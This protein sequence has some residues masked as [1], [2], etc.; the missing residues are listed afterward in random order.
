M[1]HLSRRRLVAIGPA[2][3]VALA[4][5]AHAVLFSG[6]FIPFWMID[7]AVYRGAGQAVLDGQRLYET[8]FHN[9]MLFTYPPFA[10][11]VAVPV[12]LLPVVAAQFTWT[13]V[14]YLALSAS[15]WMVLRLTGT[16]TAR[17]NTALLV[18]ACTAGASLLAPVQLNVLLGQVN[19][20]LMAL[21]LLDF[22]PAL[23]ERYRGIATGIAAGIKLT[24]LFFVAYL[25]F[26]GRRRAACQAL[27]AFAATVLVG[28]ALLLADSRAYW[29]QGVFFDTTRISPNNLV[30]N[31]SLAGFFAR[32]SAQG[33]APAWALAV[34]AVVAVACLAGAVWAHRRGHDVVGLLVIAFGAQLVSPITWVHHGVWVVPALV[35][36]ATATW[37]RATVLPRVL[38]VLGF[39]WYATPLW[40]IGMRG[41]SDDLPFSFTPL[42]NLFVTLTGIV[43][44]AAIVIALLPVWLPRL[45]PARIG[46]TEPGSAEPVHVAPADIAPVGVAPVDAVPEQAEPQQARPQATHTS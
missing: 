1:T 34:S 19:L 4:L 40:I 20:L 27:A 12:A 13:A 33:T 14:G 17:R 6:V 3:A 18:A 30:V 15:V 2:L 21:I 23:P 5:A 26:T 36:L 10:A 24:P 22:L 8:G 43:T 7:L 29:L 46:P 16:T 28:S 11:V 45:R 31:Y 35:W 39:A 25:F 32:L 38:L 41:P 42:G 9:G 44:P 37:R